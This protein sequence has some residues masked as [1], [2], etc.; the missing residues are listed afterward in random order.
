MTDE[1]QKDNIISVR[2]PKKVLHF[3]DGILEIFDDD[4]KENE[5]IK[6]EP[7]INEVSCWLSM[8]L[9]HQ[10]LDRRTTSNGLARQRN[11]FTP[12]ILLMCQVLCV[13]RPVTHRLRS[14][15]CHWTL[16]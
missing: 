3:S 9:L 11:N 13:H 6:V 4:E 10:S 2:K 5:E 7:E 14:T 16:E 1:E 8:S 12:Y 15:M